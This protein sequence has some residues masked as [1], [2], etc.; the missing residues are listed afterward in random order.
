MRDLLIKA[1]WLEDIDVLSINEQK[2]VFY[3]L[4]KHGIFEEEVNID[5]LDKSLKLFVNAII[6][7]IDRIQNRHNESVENGKKGVRKP[8]S[9]P[10]EVWELAQQG[11]S[12]VQIAERLGD[13]V[14]NIYK[15]QG[16]KR[17]KLEFELENSLE[18]PV[19]NSSGIPEKIEES[20]EKEE[21]KVENQWNF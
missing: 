8:K 20:L 11:L 15:N 1:D 4:M 14:D 16:W 18:I 21:K 7:Q 10:K 5:S 3:V 19:E 6:K 13:K 9:D 2:E 12:A 17:R